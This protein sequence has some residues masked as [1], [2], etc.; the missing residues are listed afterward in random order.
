MPFYIRTRLRRPFWHPAAVGA[1]TML[2]WALGQAL[3]LAS[4]PHGAPPSALQQGMVVLA[5]TIVGGGVAGALYWALGL[6]RFLRSAPLRWVA[7]A[8]VVMVY[9]VALALAASQAEPG[10]AWSRVGRATFLLSTLLLSLVVGWLIANDPF[11][12]AA[13]TERV[14]LTPAAFA[15]LPQSE[16][17]LL[18]PDS[19]SPS[20][21]GAAGGAG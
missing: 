18:R 10:G 3:L 14:Y 6:P 15:A 1:G 2:I 17:E 5:L 7:A 21:P 8:P 9:L 20:D 12:L 19:T 13:S 4:S 11:G 16:Q